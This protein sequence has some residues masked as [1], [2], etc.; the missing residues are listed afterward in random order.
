MMLL[1]ARDVVKVYESDGIRVAAVRDVDLAVDA[2]EFLAVMGPSGCGKSTLLHLLGGLVTPTE[3]DVTLAGRSLATM[4]DDERADMRRHAVGFVFQA[5][6]LVPV[7][8]VEEN[9]ALPPRL[10][11]TPERAWRPRVDELLA[12]MDIE[13]HRHQR[14]ARLSGGEQQR[15]AIARALVME[16]AVLLADEPTGNLDSGTGRHVLDA[17]RDVHAAGQSIV[18]VTH[19][20]KVACL[21]D[22]VLLMRDGAIVRESSLRGKKAT[23][24][25]LT[26]MIELELDEA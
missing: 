21:G 17:L 26:Q 12:A 23:P 14:P 5:Y 4:S 11:G 1:E 7:L 22:R 6:N 8:T 15:V 20:P 16:P 2:G 10:A 18:L 19:D 24:R 3:G 9:V 25:A 13:R